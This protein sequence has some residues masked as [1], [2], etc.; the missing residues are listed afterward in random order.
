MISSLEIGQNLFRF[1]NSSSN[2]DVRSFSDRIVFQILDDTWSR[3]KEKVLNR[4]LHQGIVKF[5]QWH[6]WPRP[7]FLSAGVTKR[8]ELGMFQTLA[9]LH[10]YCKSNMYWKQFQEI[11]F[12]L[13]LDCICMK[14]QQ[15][16]NFIYNR[17]SSMSWGNV[18]DFVTPAL[19]KLP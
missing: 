17:E 7:V 6:I 3:Y 2:A 5:V 19:D 10:F 13:V 8:L 9:N 16:F 14:T 4:F 15:W 18:K 12:N 11:Q 1:V